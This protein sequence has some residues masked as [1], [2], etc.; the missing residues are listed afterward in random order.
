MMSGMGGCEER[1]KALMASSVVEGIRL[2]STKLGAAGFDPGG[3]AAS[4]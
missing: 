2:M 4:I 1:R 3:E